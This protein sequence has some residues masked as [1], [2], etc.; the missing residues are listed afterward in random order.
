MAKRVPFHVKVLREI[1]RRSPTNEAMIAADLHVTRP[2]VQ[3]VVDSAERMGFLYHQEIPGYPPHLALTPDGLEYL[4]EQEP[5]WW[6][7]RSM[8]R[9]LSAM[10]G[11]YVGQHL[12]RLAGSRAEAEDFEKLLRRRWRLRGPASSLQVHQMP[13][14]YF[15]DRVEYL[16]DAERSSG[17]PPMT[18][19]EAE[20]FVSRAIARLSSATPDEID[21]YNPQ[22]APKDPED[23][24]G[25]QRV[26]RRRR[27]R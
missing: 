5:G 24:E 23:V 10:Y 3:R 1:A 16:V 14:G 25:S 13:L 18:R 6:K 7:R 9:D 27:R 11:V 19:R 15:H 12:V 21:Y 17:P 8:S 20:D 4:R 26:T 2:S 22:H